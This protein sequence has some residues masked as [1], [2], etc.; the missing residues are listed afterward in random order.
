[1]KPDTIKIIVP[2]K[3]VNLNCIKQFQFNCINE[4]NKEDVLIDI[5]SKLSKQVIIIF[6]NNKTTLENLSTL[7]KKKSMDVLA[8]HGNI[9]QNDRSDIMNKF[10]KSGGIL[11]ATNLISRG[12]DI[13]ILSVVINYDIPNDPETYIHRVGRTGRNGK[14]GMAITLTTD[15]TVSRLEDI[16]NKFNIA[17]PTLPK[18]FDLFTI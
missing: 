18:K 4:N 1:M 5:V 11:I 15:Q 7:L 10:R 13:N 14:Y 3:S 16:M 12:I 6:V 8:I 2:E 17:I 9:I